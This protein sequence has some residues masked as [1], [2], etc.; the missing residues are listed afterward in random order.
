MS[1]VLG[2]LMSTISNNNIIST[3]LMCL[4]FVILLTVGI[5]WDEWMTMLNNKR[6]IKNLKDGDVIYC[7][8]WSV[9]DYSDKAIQRYFYAIHIKEGKLKMLHEYNR[10]KSSYKDI[11]SHEPDVGRYI[12][13]RY[14][15]IDVLE[16]IFDDYCILIGDDGNKTSIKKIDLIDRSPYYKSLFEKGR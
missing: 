11:K 9:S 1:I 8:T 14:K 16:N 13:G 2:L 12:Y 5:Y 7:E 6:I 10:L 15:I 3:I 4:P